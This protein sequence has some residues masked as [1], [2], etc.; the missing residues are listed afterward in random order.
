MSWQIENAP[1]LKLAVESWIVFRVER[2]SS[3]A[4]L[5]VHFS[6]VVGSTQFANCFVCLSTLFQEIEPIPCSRWK[7]SDVSS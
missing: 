2:V 1:L 5:S 4:F 6:I 7:H 3:D